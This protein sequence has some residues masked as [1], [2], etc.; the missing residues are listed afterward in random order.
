MNNLPHILEY[1]RKQNSRS[2]KL[3]DI[4]VLIALWVIREE[5]RKPVSHV[6]LGDICG[7]AY[8][9]IRNV[10]KRLEVEESLTLTG[11][12]GDTRIRI[13]DKGVDDIEPLIKLMGVES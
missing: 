10:C 5:K 13:T 2:I 11:T 1:L 8:G 12:K 9:Q 6:E 4:T 3:T 7:I